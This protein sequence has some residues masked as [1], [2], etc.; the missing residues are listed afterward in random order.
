MNGESTQLYLILTPKNLSLKILRSEFSDITY[1]STP[2]EFNI[3]N[4]ALDMT[5]NVRNYFK[6]NSYLQLAMRYL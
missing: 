4:D 6:I 3:Y 2:F 1:C 5:Q